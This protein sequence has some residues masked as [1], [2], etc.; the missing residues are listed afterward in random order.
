MA[1]AYQEIPKQTLI[2]LVRGL[3]SDAKQ[4]VLG[5]LE[6]AKH[7]IREEIGKTKSVAMSMSLG[8]ALATIGILLLILMLVHMLNTLADIPLWV[9][10]GS[11]GILLAA[12]GGG[13]L[14]TAKKKAGEISLKPKQTVETIKEN[15]RWIKN[16]MKS[17]GV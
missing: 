15:V 10:Y 3:I 8:I 5:E 7:E 9:C 2:S 16:E 17:G 11:V 1:D 12:V 4:L 6:L 13:L 14:V